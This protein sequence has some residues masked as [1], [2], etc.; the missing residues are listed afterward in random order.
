LNFDV[1]R[2]LIDATS[3]A[4]SWSDDERADRA[5]KARYAFDTL[6]DG[7]DLYGR[8]H[9][10]PEQ[11]AESAQAHRFLAE[12]LE[13]WPDPE[14]DELIHAALPEPLALHLEAQ[15]RPHQIHLGEPECDGYWSCDNCGATFN[16]GEADAMLITDRVGHSRLPADI[17]ICRDCVLIAAAALSGTGDE[18]I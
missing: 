2:D 3:S 9:L 6:A 8:G 1:Y 12:Y 15:T 7:G 13:A 17:V 11:R 18:G 10:T 16:A 4:S 5:L 14:L